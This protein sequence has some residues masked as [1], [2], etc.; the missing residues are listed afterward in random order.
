MGTVAAI[1]GSAI[2]GGA[3]SAWSNKK[4][5]EASE[6]GNNRAIAATSAATEQARD[7][8]NRLFPQAQ[9]RG[10]QGYQQ[11]LDVFGQSLPAQMDTFQQGN[12]GAQQAILSG[13]PQIQ[14]AL[15]GGNI[16]YSGFQP[17]Q[18]QMPDTGFFNQQLPSTVANQ[19]HQSEMDRILAQMQAF[20]DNGG[21]QDHSRW[22]QYNQAT[23][24]GN[25]I[26]EL[27]GIPQAGSAASGLWDKGRTSPSLIE[28]NRAAI[29]RQERGGS[30]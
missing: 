2:L 26:L 23:G 13:L 4:A 30:R 3:V 20:R 1:G 28:L 5:S 15:M 11:A 19:N 22:D 17:Y 29:L 9:A 24:M 8:I 18:T 16:D 27:S 25:R 12:I 7:D 10:Q 6:R 21:V 14:N